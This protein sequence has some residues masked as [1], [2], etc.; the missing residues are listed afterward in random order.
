MDEKTE[1]SLRGRHLD[2]SRE[3]MS[4]GEQRCDSPKYAYRE[5]SAQ[6]F[7]QEYRCAPR[8]IGLPGKM[9][10][11]ISVDCETPSGRWPAVGTLA[12]IKDSRTFLT[13]WDGV[14]LEVRRE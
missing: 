4:N 2:Y 9:I 14:F 13:L 1:K 10:G 12:L 8:D 7:F 5:V 6:A 3:R 11:E